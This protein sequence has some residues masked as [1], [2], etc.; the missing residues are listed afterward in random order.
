MTPTHVQSYLVDSTSTGTGSL[1]T[2]SF[3]PSAGEVIV[4]WVI[5]EWNS[6]PTIGTTSGGSLTYTQRAT[7]TP[8]SQCEMRLRTAVVGGSPSSMTI[9]T[10]FSGTAGHRAMVVSR[11]SGAALATTPAVNSTV[12]GS[13][14][15]S[16]TVT[17]TAA[18]SVVCFCDA[19]RAGVGGTITYRSSA[20]SIGNDTNPA[21]NYYAA[22]FV[23]ASAGS[24]TIGM[25]APTG[26]TWTM[27]GIEILDGMKQASGSPT[28]SAI[29]LDTSRTG[30]K[31]I[32]VTRSAAMAFDASRTAFK[33]ALATPS[34]SAITLGAT[35]TGGRLSSGSP[36]ASA[37][38]FGASVI[39]R[40]VIEVTASPMTFGA[41]RTSKKIGVGAPSTSAMNFA[42]SVASTFKRGL[43]APTATVSLTASLSDV[44]KTGGNPVPVFRPKL[45]PLKQ[46]LRLIAQRILD[47]AWLDWDL[48][49]QDVE[50]TQ[51]LSGP[52][53]INGYFKP[54]VKSITEL[55]LDAWACYIHAEID[56]EIRA[57]GI[58]MPPGYEDEKL[59]LEAVGI[60]TYPHGIP[61]LGMEYAGIEVDPL[62]VV[63]IMWAHVQ[64]YPE[65]NL[66]ATLDSTHSPKTVGEP[67]K[68][69]VDENG[70][71][72]FKDV[73]NSDGVVTGQEPEM[74]EAKPYALMWWDLLDIG[75]EIDNLAKAT[76]FDY[77]ES[78]KW[79][80]DKTDVLQHIGLAYPRK[81]KKRFDLRFAQDENIIDTVAVQEGDS[82]YA[83][84][85]I[86]VGAGEGRDAVRG[87][88]G[89]RYEKRLRRV[90]YSTQKNVKSVLAANA[91]ARDELLSRRGKML[92][93]AE[94][95]V[96]AEH[97][98]AKI[99]EYETGDDI[100]VEVD[101]PWLG[102][103]GIWHRITAYKYRPDRDLVTISLQRSD[104]FRY[105]S[106]L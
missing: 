30:N 86:I 69:K 3:T 79:N 85:V 20:T 5:N 37:M 98:N 106:T 1:T 96:D 46:P 11:F 32:T 36:T 89:E 14:A 105:G 38:T 59:T 13:G 74:E 71:L 73:T 90:A 72:V 58:L 68:Q 10:A 87:Y 57:S 61:W 92:E 35:R 55:N 84:A 39:G 65:G 99:G 29:T 49:V 56:G 34:A 100:F 102:V 8:G 51:S 12:T 47:K 6:Q 16:A 76:P 43:G 83:S 24:Q 70:Q 91:L 77:Y 28:A 53:I 26:Q 33:K 50:I 9:S 19:D 60:S 31:I 54:D 22:R 81:G 18:N 23:A 97:P 66:G 88:T 48:P 42:A 41:T 78:P 27:L 64:S 101:V 94:I 45:P 40:K 95:T 4:V 25:T 2:S 63:R 44:V 75:S 17:T 80:A 52:A 82:T 67:E 93:I 15:P 103:L 21:F 104:S 62:D 7:A